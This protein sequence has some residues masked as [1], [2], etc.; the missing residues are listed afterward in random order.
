[1]TKGLAKH[2]FFNDRTAE[3]LNGI[4]KAMNVVAGAVNG[5]E[6]AVNGLEGAVNGLEG[7]VNGLCPFGSCPHEP[8]FFFFLTKNY[9]ILIN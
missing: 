7:A 1:L 3:Q 4:A 8:I 6:G 9:K 5:L 2:L